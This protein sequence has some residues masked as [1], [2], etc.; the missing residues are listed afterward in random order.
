MGLH[1]TDRRLIDGIINLLRN[2]Y[3]YTGRWGLSVASFTGQRME[4]WEELPV[5]LRAAQGRPERLEKIITELEGLA[6]HSGERTAKR[7]SLVRRKGFQHKEVVVNEQL[8]AILSALPYDLL[9]AFFGRLTSDDLFSAPARFVERH[10]GTHEQLIEPDFL[11][12]A[13]GHL[14]MGE[15]KI[16]ASRGKSI[17]RYDANQLFNYL[18]LV[19]KSRQGAAENLPNRFS[20]MLV[21]PTI[22]HRWLFRGRE[23]A[24]HLQVGPDK[25]M[26]I[27]ADACFALAEEDK[28]QR[29]ITSAAALAALLD[30][31]PVYC[32]TYDDLAHALCVASSGYPL[33]EHW[34]RLA[35]ELKELAGVAS[36]GV[37][38]NEL[39]EREPNHA[40]QRT[41]RERRAG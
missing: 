39:E 10:L 22:D 12:M 11:V 17:T 14:L 23:W 2:V 5:R 35:R 18:S 4:Y 13:D 40:L 26:K 8:L 33:K 21:L 15:I 6:G 34:D 32:R 38:K 24:P 19:V 29:Y 31:I 37:E 16:N 41:R 20:H 28:K 25:R 1:F 9:A 36:A 3:Y 27:D 30:E 7:Q